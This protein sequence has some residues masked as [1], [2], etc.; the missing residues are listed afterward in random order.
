MLD[1]VNKY[2]K[3]RNRI[4]QNIKQYQN[5]TIKVTLETDSVFRTHLIRLDS[6]ITLI[7]YFVKNLS[8]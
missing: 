3:V 5:W 4:M 2:D 8:K 1:K 7:N 6:S